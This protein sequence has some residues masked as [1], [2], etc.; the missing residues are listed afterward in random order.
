MF[1]QFYGVLFSVCEC[2]L[3]KS[4]KHRK[5]FRFAKQFSW[6]IMALLNSN[7][8]PFYFYRPVTNRYQGPDVWTGT[9]IVADHDV[10]YNQLRDDARLPQCSGVS[11]RSSR[12]YRHFFFSPGHCDP[13]ETHN[14]FPSGS[15][16]RAK[17]CSTRKQILNDLPWCELWFNMY[18]V[19]LRSVERLNET[20]KRLD[21]YLRK[22]VWQIHTCINDSTMYW[23]PL[24]SALF[25]M[26]H[27]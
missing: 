15:Y 24:D 21:T 12:K 5:R 13:P 8:A 14:A 1:S 17:S 20:T 16:I 3:I 11:L 10:S 6:G 22:L 23:C 26:W 4:C 7:S 27:G 25:H 19:K 18:S 9:I 2:V